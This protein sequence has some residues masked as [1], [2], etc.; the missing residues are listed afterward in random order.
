MDLEEIVDRFVHENALKHGEAKTASVMGAI[1]NGHPELKNRA[2]DIAPIVTRRV[3]WINNLDYESIEKRC[4]EKYPEFFEKEKKIK[5]KKTEL[6]PLE[7]AIDGQVCTRLPPEPSGYL[8]VGHG[9]A[10]FINHYYARRYHGKVILR[11]EDTNPDKVKLKY[12]DSICEDYQYM[13]IDWDEKVIESDRVPI[14]QGYARELI[15]KGEAYVCSCQKEVVRE[16]RREGREC[17]HRFQSIEDTLDKW[18]WMLEDAG[19]GDATLRIRGDMQSP[20]AALHDPAIMRVVETPHCLQGDKYR[21]WPLYDF[22]VSIEDGVLGITHVLR[23]E[24]FVQKVPLQNLIRD[25]L[26]LPSPSFIHFSRLRL[27]DAPV[28]KR[29]IRELI[30]K[31]II[32]AWNDIRLATLSG[33]RRRGIV[34]ETI[35]QLAFDMQLSTSQSKMDM[36][37]LL[38]LNS[39]IIDGIAKRCFAVI[40]PVVLRVADSSGGDVELAIHPK[41]SGLGSRKLP[42]GSA[43]YVSRSDIDLLKP[44]HTVRLKDLFNISVQEIKRDSNDQL[45]VNASIDESKSKDFDKIQWVP[46]NF[47]K[48]LLLNIPG[49]LYVNGEINP[50]SLTIA[51][52]FIEQSVLEFQVGDLLQL[53]RIGYGRI[54]KLSTDLIEI[55]LT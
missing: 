45:V 13:G 30:E 31:G 34:P 40:D 28:Q 7:G 36:S 53:E 50:E 3:T 18:E 49:L 39:K 25:K 14:Y 33:M 21:V 46:A 22:A 24:E 16:N 55:N 23:S 44:G 9:Y 35:R 27:I 6:P 15:E 37:Y 19:K 5:E 41:N 38:S 10:G 8:H 51:K 2:K 11:F 26:G 4:R 42:Y 48:E 52:G 47:S 1:I 32:E 17:E 20:K 54:D 43:F 12:Y 29:Q